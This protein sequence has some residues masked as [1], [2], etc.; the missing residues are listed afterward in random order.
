MTSLPMMKGVM[1]RYKA[2]KAQ[3]KAP[4]KDRERDAQAAR[5][6][7]KDPGGGGDG[8]KKKRS[9]SGRREVPPRGPSCAST[10]G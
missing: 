8:G 9:P 2:G 4:K 1:M 10:A 6:L 3:K 7:D 5:A